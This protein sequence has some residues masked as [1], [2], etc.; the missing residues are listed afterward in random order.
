VDWSTR[1]LVNSP[2]ANFFNHRKIITYK[3]TKQQRNT[4][5]NPIDY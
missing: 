3:Y 5:T 2:T 4:N 1:G